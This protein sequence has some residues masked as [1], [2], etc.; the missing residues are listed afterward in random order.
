MTRRLGIGLAIVALSIFQ[1]YHNMAAE[2]AHMETWDGIYHPSMIGPFL[3]SISL[4]LVGFI[5]GQVVPTLRK[6]SD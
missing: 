2:I 5:S 6:G 1:A 3:D 4:T